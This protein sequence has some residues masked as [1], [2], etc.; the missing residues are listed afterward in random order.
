LEN[1]GIDLDADQIGAMIAEMDTDGS[2][3]ISKDEFM[4]YLDSIKDIIKSSNV[5]DTGTDNPWSWL[6]VHVHVFGIQLGYRKID[7]ICDFRT[8]MD[9]KIESIIAITG[10][11]ILIVRF[12]QRKH[13]ES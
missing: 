13:R 1:H 8:A 5:E 4:A 3:T 9:V 7:C 11:I 2:E 6:W 10:L 12:F